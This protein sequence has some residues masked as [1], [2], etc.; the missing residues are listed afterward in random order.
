MT[1]SAAGEI[2]TVPT[3]KHGIHYVSLIDDEEDY[4]IQDMM[5]EALAGYG[6]FDFSNRIEAFVF[7]TEREVFEEYLLTN[8]DVTAN[9]FNDRRAFHYDFEQKS[10][11]GVEVSGLETPTLMTYA[12]GRVIEYARIRVEGEIGLPYCKRPGYRYWVEFFSE[13]HASLNRNKGSIFPDSPLRNFIEMLPYKEEMFEKTEIDLT[14]LHLIDAMSELAYYV[15]NDQ[16]DFVKD[17]FC[18]LE[19]NTDETFSM[20]VRDL[21]EMLTNYLNKAGEFY[22]AP[23]DY[24]EFD[25]IESYKNKMTDYFN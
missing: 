10:I 20:L 16:C 4:D 19:E 11:I 17:C 18:E 14:F 21:F 15:K 23:H 25:K 13:T 3:T 24:A 6:E 9:S 1:A 7:Y 8:F 12:L 22:T 5:T 2:M